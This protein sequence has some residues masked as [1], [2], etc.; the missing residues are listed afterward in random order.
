MRWGLD[1][2]QEVLAFLNGLLVGR[3]NFLDE[4]VKIVAVYF[5]YALPLIL[6]ILWFSFPERR[7]ALWLSFIACMISWLIIAKAIVPNIWF[8]ARPD[9][10]LVGA[11]ELLFHRP[12]YS[13]PSDH[14]AALFAI[15]FG[16]YAFGWKRAGHW[17]LTYAVVVSIARV[18]VGVHFPLDIIAGA[19]VAAIGVAV[20]ALL[21]KPL[22]KYLMD[23]I[24][25]L[26]H[27]VG[28][29]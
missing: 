26:M 14:A 27:K 9:L 29:K 17:F 16:L 24:V 20:A 2:D 4:L 13:F 8:R 18:A 11:K 19:A 25:S 7:E 1:L 6:L 23:P 12:D 21:R 22:V 28:I 5:I 3:S 10:E 15:C